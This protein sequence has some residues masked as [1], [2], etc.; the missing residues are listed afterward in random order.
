MSRAGKRLAQ[1][2]EAMVSERGRGRGRPPKAPG[3]AHMP[4]RTLRV[5]DSLW[6]R[7][8]AAARRAGVSVAQWI[9]AACEERLRRE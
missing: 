6:G 8:Q 2:E 4:I 5:S 3:T 1:R 9:R 7:I